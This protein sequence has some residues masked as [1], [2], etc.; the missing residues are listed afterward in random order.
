MRLQ[1][2][3]ALARLLAALATLLATLLAS[4]L[5]ARADGFVAVR[6]AY[7]KERSTRVEQPMVDG[8]FD[9]GPRDRLA[10][11]L[12]VDSITSAS[13]ATGAGGAEFTE[14]RYEGALD[15]T[16]ELPGRLKLGVEGRYSTESDYFSTWLGA[17]GELSLFEQTTI[18]RLLVGH[19]FDTITNGIAVDTGAIGTPHIQESLDTTL[20]S[21][22]V[23][24][25]LTPRMLAQLTYDLALLEGYQANLYRIVRGGTQPVPERVPDERLRHAVAVAWRYFVPETKTTLALSY[26]LYLDDWGIVAHTPE[27]RVIQSFLDGRLDVRAR[28]RFYTQVAADFYQPV[29]TQAELMDPTVWV[30]ADAKL[31]SYETVT[32]GGQISMALSAIGW[33]GAGSDTRLDL[34]V[35]RVWQDTAFGDAWIGQLGLVVP[36]GY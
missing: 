13:S 9:V 2:T 22:G 17:H 11:H 3:A 20:F 28:F 27:A 26:R 35:E 31:G 6:G 7:Y 1:L 5:P 30:T 29:Y 4:S 24:Q 15:V 32:L 12:L 16:H 36:F 33:K 19:S 8:A 34:V 25:V 18:F 14:R 10:G 21:L 23:T